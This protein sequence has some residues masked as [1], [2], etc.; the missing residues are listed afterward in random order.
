MH[1]ARKLARAQRELDLRE[2]EQGREA[3]NTKESPSAAS[4]D[5]KQ[6][7]MELKIERLKAIYRHERSMVLTLWSNCSLRETEET[8]LDV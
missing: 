1:N 5:N 7:E 6:M 4:R 2:Q 3:Q 8:V